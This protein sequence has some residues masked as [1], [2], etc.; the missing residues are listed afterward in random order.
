MRLISLMVSMLSLYSK[1]T[2]A[3]SKPVSGILVLLSVKMFNS[4]W[5][6]IISPN[7]S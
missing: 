5:R 4:T 1:P 6:W 3:F 2:R 7:I